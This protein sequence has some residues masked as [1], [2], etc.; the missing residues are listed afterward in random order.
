MQHSDTAVILA[1]GRGSR[2][3]EL[4]L[5]QPKPMTM[6]NQTS[7][8]HN[9]I[10]HLTENGFRRIVVV[11]GYFAKKLQ[12][13]IL[14]VFEGQAEFIFV[15]NKIFD[16][17]NNIY[18]LWLAAEYLKEG[19]YLFEADVFCDALL[20]KKLKSYPAKD[21]ILLGAY[22]EQMNGTVVDINRNGMIKNMYLKRHQTEP[23][24]FNG[25]YKTINFYKLSADF[26]NTF[27]LKRLQEH[28]DRED[29]NSYYELIIKEAIDQRYPFFGLLA[30]ESN[31]WEIDTLE[32]LE[33]AEGIFKK[34]GR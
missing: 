17:T 25:K 22:T 2:L 9:L 7:I 26:V 31:W 13:S 14:N 5:E 23:F 10:R 24:D 21:I 27:F 6:V 11:T 28:I 29:V 3:K 4:S 30:E 34:G 32:D 1:A 15:E 19:F 18:S 12:Q 8:I 20:I 33:I 16:S